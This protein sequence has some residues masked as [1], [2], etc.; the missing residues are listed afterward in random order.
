M[1]KALQRVYSS[2]LNHLYFLVRAENFKEALDATTDYF[3]RWESLIPREE[4]N[5]SRSNP[6]GKSKTLFFFTYKRKNNV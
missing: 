3:T 4:F 6:I 5:L 2:D 1:T